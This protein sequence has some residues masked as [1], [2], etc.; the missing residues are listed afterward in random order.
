MA[1][2]IEFMK[3]SRMIKFSNKVEVAKFTIFMRIGFLECKQYSAF[4]S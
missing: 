2:T 1:R 4:A 3:M